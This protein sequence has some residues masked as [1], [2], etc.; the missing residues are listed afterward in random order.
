[1][2]V[3]GIPKQGA[4]V[5]YVIS[6]AATNLPLSIAWTPSPC[7]YPT[8]NYFITDSN[9]GDVSQVLTISSTNIQIYN[10]DLT[11]ATQ[12]LS[13]R[14]WAIPVANPSQAPIDKPMS[15]MDNSSYFESSCKFSCAVVTFNYIYSIS[16]NFTS[17]NANFK[18]WCSYLFNHS[19][20][21]NLS[22]IHDIRFNDIFTVINTNYRNF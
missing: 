11:R 9:A 5:N 20:P 10:N 8:Y 7:T 21:T 17:Y 3:T 2:T 14:Y 6:S 1:M 19:L 22:H 12:T 18:L 4:S 13:I 15:Y 16:A